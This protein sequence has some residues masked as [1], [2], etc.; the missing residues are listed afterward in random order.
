MIP[1]QQS[2]L[3]VKLCPQRRKASKETAESDSS[4][5]FGTLSCVPVWTSLPYFDC[6]IIQLPSVAKQILRF[7]LA[8]EWPATILGKGSTGSLEVVLVTH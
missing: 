4:K 8:K 2:S 5:L 6:K 1:E 7:T 3:I